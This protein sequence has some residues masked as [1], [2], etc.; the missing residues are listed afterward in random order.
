MWIIIS[1]KPKH[2]TEDVQYYSAVAL[3]CVC[4]SAAVQNQQ[5]GLRITLAGHTAA[6]RVLGGMG[7]SQSTSQNQCCQQHRAL[8]SPAHKYLNHTKVQ[9]QK[10]K[11]GT[12]LTPVCVRAVVVQGHDTLC[13]SAGFGSIDIRM[14][15]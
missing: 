8:Q 3:R 9:S 1:T 12:D 4:L 10:Q 6:L 7:T 15:Q 2:C 5:R 13:L 11:H 14:L